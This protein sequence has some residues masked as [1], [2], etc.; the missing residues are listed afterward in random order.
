MNNIGKFKVGTKFV[1]NTN[2]LMMEVIKIE[3]N[4][5]GTE[6]GYVKVESELVTIKNIETGKLFTYGL[7]GLE[8]CD[9]TIIAR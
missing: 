2:K 8:R 3:K 9:I 6:S 1:G 7:Q 4:C 5:T